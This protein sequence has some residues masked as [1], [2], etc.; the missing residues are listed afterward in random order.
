MPTN[1][2]FNMNK[3]EKSIKQQSVQALNNRKYDVT[4]PHCGAKVKV[5]T[6]KS[7]C[8]RCHNQIDLSLDVSFTK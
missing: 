4:C 2:K 6:G 8:P 7:S 1:F 5:P 3:L